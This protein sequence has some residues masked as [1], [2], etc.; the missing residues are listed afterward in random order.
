MASYYDIQVND[1]VNKEAA[2]YYPTPEN[3]AKQIA[4]HVAFGKD[5]KV[6]AKGA[7]LGASF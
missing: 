1:Q 2:W 6:E 3:R 4:G 5:V 7:E